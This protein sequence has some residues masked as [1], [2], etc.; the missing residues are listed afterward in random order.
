MI[1]A[2]RRHVAVI[3]RRAERQRWLVAVILRRAERQR[4]LVAVILRRAERQR[5]TPIGSLSRQGSSPSLRRPA[6][7]V[8]VETF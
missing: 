5:S 6:V 4:W 2:R 7:W 8:L 3:V 1:F